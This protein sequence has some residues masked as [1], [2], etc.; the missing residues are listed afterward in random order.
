MTT[1]V[2]NFQFALTR[3]MGLERSNYF[4]LL[5]EPIFVCNERYCFQGTFIRCLQH[6]FLVSLFQDS[7]PATLLSF[8]F[9]SF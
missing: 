3:V 9:I 2:V 8:S 4:S 5:E 6:S 1:A 7:M